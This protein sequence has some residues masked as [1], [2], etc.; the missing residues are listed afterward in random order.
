M[1]DNFD[2][3]KQNQ[4]A[5]EFHALHHKEE[6]LLL[7][8]AWD[9]LSA[10]LVEREGLPAIATTSS[11]ISWSCGYAD[12]E[13]TPPEMMIEEVRKIARAVDIPVSADIES[14]YYGDNLKALADFTDKIIKAGAIGINLEDSDPKT[15][16]LL[17][18]EQNVQKIK[19][20]RQKTNELGVPLYINAR[21]DAMTLSSDLD[22][23]L[24]IIF[25]R[26]KAYQ[27]A[28]ASGIFVPFINDMGTVK[29]VKAGIELPLNIL[30]AKTL[31]IQELKNLK[32]N[33]ISVGGRP[34][35]AAKSVF[36]KI[37]EEM[38]TTNQWDSLYSGELTHP[39]TNSWFK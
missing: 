19:T 30:M 37:V 12:G 38:K 13:H 15:E 35:L 2:I 3:Q 7:V 31:D 32:I 4:L 24:E 22:E 10:K 1:K 39:Q 14:G 18:T 23:K 20:V 36:K 5:E 8:N 21:I 28:G 11:G 27:R 26:A 33:R 17:S 9:A 29:A 25:K 6:P 16:G 34:S